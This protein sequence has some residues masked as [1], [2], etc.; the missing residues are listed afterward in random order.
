MFL[1]RS[2]Y[3]LIEIMIVMAIIG[4]LSVTLYPSVMTY[5]A[6]G[7]DIERIAGVKQI[8]IAVTAYQVNKQVL[9]K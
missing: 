3:T 6:R 2:A 8:S 5:L 4:I 1:R 9:P 7:R